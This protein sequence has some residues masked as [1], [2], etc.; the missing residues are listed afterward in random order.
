M[1]Q[2]NQKPAQPQQGGKNQTDRDQQQRQQNEGG[3]QQ[4]GGGKSDRK[5]DQNR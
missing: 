5:P 2:K 1:D 4:Q 3:K